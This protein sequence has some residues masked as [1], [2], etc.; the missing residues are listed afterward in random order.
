MVNK[1]TKVWLEE[2]KETWRI[3]EGDVE[4]GEWIF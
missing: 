3:P 4:T 1:I 2:L